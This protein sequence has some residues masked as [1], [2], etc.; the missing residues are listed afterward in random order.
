MAK[1]RNIIFDLGGVFIE[2]DYAATRKAFI[3]LGIKN[4][5]DLYRQDFVSTLFEDLEIGKISERDF[6]NQF[7]F[8]LNSQLS[9]EQIKKTWNAMLGNFWMNRLEFAMVLKERYQV[10]L[11]S[12]TN[13][14]HLKCFE[15]IFKQAY[16]TKIFSQYFHQVYYSHKMQLR[17][18]NADCYLKILHEHHLLA[19]ETLFVDDTL[20][21]IQGAQKV[22]L[23]TLH[24]KPHMNLIKSVSQ[25]LKFP[26]K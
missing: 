21:N 8:I 13:E 6:Y 26:N 12:N 11:L 9:N 23:K 3:D 14:I 4:F 17:K 1:I 25:F 10:F 5:D 20:I 7:R 2:V 24:L 15:K 18:P 19:R 16:P 22:A